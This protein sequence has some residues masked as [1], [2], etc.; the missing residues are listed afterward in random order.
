MVTLYELHKNPRSNSRKE[1]PHDEIF[2]KKRNWYDD[3]RHHE[4]YKPIGNAKK[5]TEQ[6]L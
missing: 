4:R 5:T 6:W 2:G 1:R 3:K